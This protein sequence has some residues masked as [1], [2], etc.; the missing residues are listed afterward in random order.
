MD[1]RPRAPGAST[2]A[3]AIS[4]LKLLLP[5]GILAWVVMTIP[6][7]DWRRFRDQP[8]SGVTFAMALV[9]LLAAVSVTF[10]RWRCLVRALGLRLTLREAFRLGFLGYLFSF[11]SFGSAGGDV[12]KAASLG[13]R[14]SGSHGAAL[15]SVIMDR[16]VGMYGL[17][18][19]VG[20]AL[21][22]SPHI[23]SEMPAVAGASVLATLLVGAVL[24]MLSRRE[25]HG[26]R[27]VDRRDDQTSSRLRRVVGQLIASLHAFGRAPGVVA[28]AFAMS[29]GV[30]ALSALA[31]W[32][33]ATAIAPAVPSLS[34]HFVIMPIASLIAALPITPAGLGTTELAL[35]ELYGLALF[36]GTDDGPG[37]IIALAY[38]LNTLAVAA[39]GMLYV[40]G[41]RERG[42]S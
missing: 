29:V 31:L 22:A 35:T 37:G 5:F 6:P 14:R 28:L 20:A 11:A 21:V 3:A 7:D 24:T 42:R 1:E 9:T 12:F 23:R 38:R 41:L 39:L 36:G 40:S 26:S 30:H 34:N 33:V 27:P 2:R 25:W 15:A 10:I 8:K 19:F 16:I 13:R 4:A 17:A 32:L 18:I